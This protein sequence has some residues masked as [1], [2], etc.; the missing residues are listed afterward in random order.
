MIAKGELA[1]REGEDPVDP[2][3][4]DKILEEA[5]LAELVNRRGQF[6]ALV[7][8]L[9]QIRVTWQEKSNSGVPVTLERLPSNVGQIFAM[10][11]SAIAKR[12]PSASLTSPPA[13]A[14]DGATEAAAEG[15]APTLVGKVG[16]SAQAASALAA[17]AKYFSSREPSS[18][19][20]LLVRQADA[21]LGKSFLEV[22]RV[23]V[24][25]HVDK[26]AVNIGKDQFFD[27]P[28]DRLSSFADVEEQPANTADGA[29][30]G[31]QF[32]IR[33]RAE[34]LALLDQVSNYFRTAEPSSPI[35]F[36]TDRARDLA[37]RDFLSVLKALLPA[38]AL[39]L[40]GEENR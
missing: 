20:L 24:P 34:A 31:P 15:A 21:L 13:G 11:D 33:T 17:V 39:R 3:A 26:A 8:A 5:E 28:I 25:T 10:L 19:A 40:N 7:E 36:L 37:Q 38:D 18:P 12:D 6:L 30:E 22:M 9:K 1:L 23:L 4:I 32:E 14:Q 27:L 35:P 29:P 2:G 16:S